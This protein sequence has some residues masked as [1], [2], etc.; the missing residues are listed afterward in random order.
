MNHTSTPSS[1]LSHRRCKIV[2]TVGPA[3]NI[4]QLVHAGVTAFRLNF[5]HGSHEDH[6]AQLHLIRQAEEQSGQ[7]IP[8]IADLQGP[9]IRVSTFESGR[10]TL[11]HGQQV[12]LECSSEA[13]KEGLIRLPH[14]ELFEALQIGDTL[15][16]DDGLMQL[17][18][19]ARDSQTHMQAVVDI[20]GILSNRKGVNTPGRQLP[21]SALTDKDKRDL[22]F[23]VDNAVEYIAL[24][25][26]QRAADVI[27]ARS[28]IG[29]STRII[30]KIE[31]PQ[32]LDELEAII[33]HSDAVM[34]ARGD[35]GVELPME[36]VPIAQRKIV[37]A[38]RHQGKPVIVATQMLQ[39]MVDTNTPTRAES[40]DVATAVYMGADA[41]M[42]SAESAVGRHPATAVAVMDRIIR[43]VEEDENYWQQRAELRRAPQ[44]NI[45]TALAHAARDTARQVNARAIFAFTQSGSTAL[46]AAKERPRCPLY[47]LTPDIQRARQ[48][49]LVWGLASTV[50]PT[51]DNL[52]SM[53]KWVEMTA[54]QRG[55][56]K[57]GDYACAIAGIPFAVEGSTNMLKVMTIE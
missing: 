28:L 39:S 15:K 48:L 52:E 35:L 30:A 17:T 38:A 47:A 46:L 36:K 6:L 41:V 4:L 9:K 29:D 10:I 24:S 13:G 51:L 26:V 44:C 31:K 14:P 42:L 7:L 56:V 12:T 50:S 37:S 1:H 43:A 20:G 54:K 22:A 34:V 16:L 25:F 40:S 57:V 32:A 19:T 18:V 45:A 55:W 53:L 5:S 27:E 21:I 11:T 3:T 2:A 23:A 49:A 33:E 8:V